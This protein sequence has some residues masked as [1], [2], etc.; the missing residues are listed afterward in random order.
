MTSLTDDTSWCPWPLP[1]ELIDAIITFLSLRDRVQ[2]MRVNRWCRHLLLTSSHYWR[3]L[4]MPIPESSFELYVERAAPRLERLCIHPGLDLARA[5]STLH[6][7]ACRSV[8]HLDFRDCQTLTQHKLAAIL[9]RM[10]HLHALNLASTAVPI[11][12]VLSHCPPSLRWLDMSACDCLDVS[13]LPER[14]SPESLLHYE[15]KKTTALECLALSRVKRINLYVLTWVV[16]RC[17]ALKSLITDA[18]PVIPPAFFTLVLQRCRALE[19]LTYTHDPALFWVDSLAGPNNTSWLSHFQE[20]ASLRTLK[21]G[22]R[23]QTTPLATLTRDPHEIPMQQ[24]RGCAWRTD[25]PMD[26]LSKAGFRCTTHPLY[27]DPLSADGSLLEPLMI[28]HAM[29]SLVVLSHVLDAL[30]YL[31]RIEL[32]S[33]QPE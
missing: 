4:D 13:D 32:D 31:E 22:S 21:I 6:R 30:P 7:H 10:P 11:E 2:F 24:A 14:L 15:A 16:A 12:W 17:P 3:Q 8:T 1:H 28:Q 23:T 20:A 18:C 9:C 29:A 27:S 25:G 5:A 19:H 33:H 26:A